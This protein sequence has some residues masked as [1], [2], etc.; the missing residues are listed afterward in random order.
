[1]TVRIAPSILS[2]DLSKL[3]D[4]IAMLEERRRRLDPHRC[5][6]WPLRS[7]STFGA[8]VIE[9]VRKLTKLPLDVH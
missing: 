7:E 8:K 4:E 5:H 2:A 9:S 1:M 6:G 3:A